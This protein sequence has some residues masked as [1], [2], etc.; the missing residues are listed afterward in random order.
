MKDIG[1]NRIWFWLRPH[2]AQITAALICAMLAAVSA[3]F[4]P[5]ITSRIIIDD[6]LLAT[7]STDLPD[8][9]QRLLAHALSE[10]TALSPLNSA[11]I[12][13]S[14]WILASGFFSYAFYIQLARASTRALSE[15]RFA[16]FAHVQRLPAAFYDRGTVGETL[17]RITTDVESLSDLLTGAGL[18]VAEVIPFAVAA[19][20]MLTTDFRLTLEILPIMP[21]VAFLNYRLRRKTTE[22]YRNVRTSLARLNESLHENLSGLEVIQL[23]GL[24]TRNLNRFTAILD[25]TKAWESRAI[26]VETVF[27]PLFENLSYVAMGFILWFGGLHALS[28]LAS[29]GTIVLFIQFS[30][31]LFRPVITLGNQANALNRARPA[32]ER[33]FRL[34][35]WKEALRLPEHPQALPD[36]LHGKIVFR[37]LTFRYETGEPALKTIDLAITPGEVIAIVGPTGSGKTTLTRLICRAYDVPEGT[38]YIDDIDIMQVAPEQLRR[39]IGVILQD[40]HIFSGTVL[41]NITLGDPGISAD[42]AIAAA[43]L[44]HALPFIEG[45]P[46]GFQT[47]LQHRGQNIS[48]GQ[49][50]LLAFARVVALNPEILILD[51]ATASIDLETEQLIQSAL[52]TVQEGR[53]TIIIAHRLQT[54]RDADRI[55]VLDHGE[56]VECGTHD[57]LMAGEGLYHKLHELQALA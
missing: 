25:Q 29:V 39:R 26:R 36:N 52:K 17:T 53:T 10:T 24:K 9:G 20:V 47:V 41:D 22:I 46:D 50:Q 4:V 12:L 7:P 33:I 13:A 42:Q 38:L 48:Q 27:L 44:V 28:G 57:A 35:D 51:E 21:A 5:V 34:L 23:S 56:I 37:D 15:L 19:G 54:I 11:V 1:L 18:V 16:L 8:Y 31:M 49:R 3:I 30:D 14:F 55:V 6:I 43:R 32:C 2:S 45:L 40:F